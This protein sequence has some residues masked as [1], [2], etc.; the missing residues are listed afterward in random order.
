MGHVENVNNHYK[1]SALLFFILSSLN[2]SDFSNHWRYKADSKSSFDFMLPFIH[3]SLHVRWSIMAKQD[4]KIVLLNSVAWDG[5][6]KDWFFMSFAVHQSLHQS[7]AN[8]LA[9]VK[10]VLYVHL[11]LFIGWKPLSNWR[12]YKD[13]STESIYSNYHQPSVTKQDM[14]N[15]LL[16][17]VEACFTH[18]RDYVFLPHKQSPPEEG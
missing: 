9:L 18:R 6:V 17:L 3:L 11:R 5:A 1:L 15:F 10:L 16:S 14:S 4:R 2:C 12:L 8:I 13:Q 7:W